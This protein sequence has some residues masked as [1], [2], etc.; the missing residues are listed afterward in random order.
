[1]PFKFPVYQRLNKEEDF[2][3][4]IKKGKKIRGRFF[5]LLFEE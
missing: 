1:M 2:K 5:F 3:K 4:L